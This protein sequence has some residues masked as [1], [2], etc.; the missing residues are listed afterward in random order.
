MKSSKF[1]FVL[2]AVAAGFSSLSL[3]DAGA[4][5]QIPCGIYDDKA[6]FATMRE[7]VAT[8]E[9]SMAQIVELGATNTNQSV[10]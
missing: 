5:C 7:H 4:H 9:K 10:R 6:R 1:F 8:I 2:A 3:Q